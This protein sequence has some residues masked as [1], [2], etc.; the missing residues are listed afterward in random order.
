[1][2]GSSHYGFFFSLGKCTARNAWCVILFG[3]TLAFIL[4][5]C[6]ITFGSVEVKIENLWIKEGGRVYEEVEYLKDHAIAGIGREFILI[7]TTEVSIEL[8]EFPCLM[9]LI[10]L[11]ELFFSILTHTPYPN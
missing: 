5:S 1:M 6:I 8:V 9:A 7:D 3:Y 11:C 10:M 4:T 2:S